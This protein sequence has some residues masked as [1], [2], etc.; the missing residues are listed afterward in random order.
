MN[1]SDPLGALAIIIVIFFGIGLHE[2]AH[3]KFAD[4][5]GDPTPR[6]YG[7]VTLNLFKH[8]ELM[9][10][11]M[12][13]ISATTGFGIGWGKPAPCDASKMRNPRW[14]FFVSVIAGPISNVLQA[15]VWTT[16]GVV[17][18]KLGLFNFIETDGVVHVSRN[19]FLPK[20]ITTGVAVNVGIACFNMIPFGVLDGHWIVGTFLPEK[21]RY[22]WYKF[23]HTYGLYIFIGLI[24]IGQSVGREY[25]QLNVLGYYYQSVVFPVTM[26]FLNLIK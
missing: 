26:F 9:G 19:D 11:I 13:F 1:L 16:I 8:F 6:Y 12:M 22:Y 24:L 10:T 23:N 2:Y 4:L 25:P 14:D 21:Q 15:I 17:C 7:R 3:C 5:A 18:L 20:L